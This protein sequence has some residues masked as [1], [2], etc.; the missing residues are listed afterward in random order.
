MMSVGGTARIASAQN[1]E[2]C[3]LFS[4]IGSSNAS[5]R[6]LA[7][8]KDENKSAIERGYTVESPAFRG[9]R[10]VY[11]RLNRTEPGTDS[12]RATYAGCGNEHTK[13]DPV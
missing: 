9:D 4:P 12:S 2:G 5:T 6:K 8:P 11:A 13:C 10:S 7:R 1:D 3:A